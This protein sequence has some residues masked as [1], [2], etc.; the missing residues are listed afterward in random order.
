MTETEDWWVLAEA[1]VR[2]LAFLQGL[3]H[4][5][6]TASVD[7]ADLVERLPRRLPDT[8]VDASWVIDELVR[9]L[10]DGLVASAGGRFFGWATGGTHPAGIAADWL[11]SS[12][13]QLAGPGPAS[14]AA[15]AAT[16][17]S[18]GG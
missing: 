18:V 1:H 11:T 15:D 6:V 9:V 13:D 14:P 17:S 2:S 12:R 4:R 10:D 5:P 7:A 8:G 16:R 3:A